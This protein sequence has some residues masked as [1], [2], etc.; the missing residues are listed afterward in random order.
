MIVASAEVMRSTVL[1]GDTPFRRAYLRSVID[2]VEVDDPEI[3]IIG[4]RSVLERLSWTARP[5]LPECPVLFRS[6]ARE[7]IR[8]PGPQIVVLK[9][10]PRLGL[11][12]RLHAPIE[13]VYAALRKRA[14]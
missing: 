1:T 12:P 8:A 5:P 13:K 9:C 10:V 4:R 7:E 14:E 3:R 6:G 11:V 2:Q